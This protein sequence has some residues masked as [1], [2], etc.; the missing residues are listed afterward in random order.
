ME[1]IPQ[2]EIPQFGYKLFAF[3][4]PRGKARPVFVGEVAE[5]SSD[6]KA[7]VNKVLP[8]AD[9]DRQYEKSGYYVGLPN[10]RVEVGSDFEISVLNRY[11]RDCNTTG[12]PFQS[13]VQYLH[14]K[15]YEIPGITTNILDL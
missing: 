2:G 10:W 9:R 11:L 14:I 15:G 3:V 1:K 7:I 6:L 8:K 12:M 4:T 5:K 13:V